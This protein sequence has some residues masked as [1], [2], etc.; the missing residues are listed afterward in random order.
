MWHK[1]FCSVWIVVILLVSIAVPLLS[2]IVDPFNIFHWDCARNNGIEPN[3]RYVRTKYILNNPLKYD[4][5]VFGSSRVGTI[6]VEKILD[7]T[8]Y[9]MSYSIGLPSEQLQTLK[10]ILNG[11]CKIKRIYIGVDDILLYVSEKSHLNL[12]QFPYEYLDEHKRNFLC[13]YVFNPKLLYSSLSYYQKEN[14]RNR[15]IIRQ[16]Y[17]TGWWADYDFKSKFQWANVEYV[18]RKFEKKDSY[19]I[20]LALNSILKLSELCKRNNIELII[21]TNPTYRTT[22]ISGL[23]KGYIEF[24]RELVKITDFYNFSGLNDVTINKENYLDT[25]HY[26]AYVGDMI[27]DVIHNNKRFDKLYEQGFGW[28]VTKDNIEKLLNLIDVKEGDC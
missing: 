24:L 1:K 6:H 21:F 19:K 27:I 2:I 9:N 4:S 11:G 3:E 23:N 20:N 12:M 17:K 28:Y 5:Y 22:Y 14:G 13:S 7:A 15:E 25:S 8:V 26:N 10:T 16:M 18:I